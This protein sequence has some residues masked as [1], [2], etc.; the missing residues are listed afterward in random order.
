MSDYS[1]YNHDEIRKWAPTLKFF[2]ICYP[3]P[4]GPLE[5]EDGGLKAAIKIEAEQDLTD[6]F[7]KLGIPVERAADR[8]T[9][10]TSN[11]RSRMS[12]FPEIYQPQNVK[13]AGVGVVVNMSANLELTVFDEQREY[14]MT[15]SAVESAR[16]VETV[17]ESV[18]NRLIDPPIEDKRCVCPQFYPEY[19]GIAP[20]EKIAAEERPDLFLPLDEN[21]DFR[22]CG[23]CS[24]LNDYES[25]SQ[26]IHGSPDDNYLPD[27]VRSLKYVREVLTKEGYKRHLRQCPKCTTCY[28]YHTEYEF[29]LGGSGSEDSQHLERLSV[30]QTKDYLTRVVPDKP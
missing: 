1:N 4:Y 15:E 6:V 8:E 24:Q 21:A 19:W 30:E 7:G 28:L 10:R 13:I 3:Y 27:A 12:R 9:E 23:I 25:A 14:D 5:D 20:P 16:R 26:S 18:A 2:R 22:Q 29:L 11:S 17:L